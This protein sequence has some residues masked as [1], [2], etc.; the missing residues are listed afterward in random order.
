MRDLVPGLAALGRGDGSTAIAI[1]MHISWTWQLARAWRLARLKGD[2]QQEATIAALL[3]EIV[4]DR[5]IAAWKRRRRLFHQPSPP[6]FLSP[7]K[8][9]SKW[10]G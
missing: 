10:P 1:N 2:N 5:L 8:L 3:R 6:Q 4:T 9:S 7:R